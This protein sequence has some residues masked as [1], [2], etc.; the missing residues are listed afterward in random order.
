MK[1]LVFA[2]HNDDEV[3][4]VG[5]TI[6][7]YTQSG[8]Q[9]IVCEVTSGSNENIV[10]KIKKEALQA[11]KLL[12]VTET[13]FLDL[14]VVNLKNLEVDKLNASFLEIVQKVKPDVA[15]I[16]HK[17]YMHIDH[18]EV[19]M[20]AMVALRPV[21]NPQLKAI[22][23]YETLSETEWS[24][25]NAENAFMPN[26]WNDITNTFTSKVEAMKC[27]QT[28]LQEF[29]HPRSL[30]A[31]DALANLRGSTIC[32]NKAEAFMCLRNVL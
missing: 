13:V 32:V 5:G 22:Y 27:Y 4:G 31:I 12:G 21:N 25:P 8:N 29:P 14:P 19:A 30:Q 26:V 11:H 1:V 2:P 15:F 20:A 24:I 3:L 28:Q 10:K 18:Y 16:P 7:K 23:A 17:G 6:A 9:V